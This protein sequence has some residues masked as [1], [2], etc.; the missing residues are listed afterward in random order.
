M[1]EEITDKDKIINYW[2][3]SSDNNYQT[4]ENLFS[5]KDYHWSLFMGH[6][7]IEKLLKGIFVKT[8]NKH[9]VFTH[10]LLRLAEKCGLKLTKEQQDI[11]DRITTFNINA[12]YDDYKKNF[13]LLCTAEFTSGWIE[14]IKTLRLWLKEKL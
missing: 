8:F 11:L 10:D 12:R 3:E 6:L 13:Y 14:K 4:M 1:N 5:S 7:V 2:I 9:A